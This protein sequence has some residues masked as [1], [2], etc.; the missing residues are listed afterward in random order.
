MMRQGV[1]QKEKVVLMGHSLGAFISVH[2][3]LTFPERVH[4][5]ILASPVGVPESPNNFNAETIAENM[6]SGSKKLFV[7]QIGKSWENH[8]SPFSIM[9][10]GGSITANKLLERYVNNRITLDSKEEKDQMRDLLHQAV[11]RP[12]SSEVAITMVLKFGAYAREPLIHLI[13][14]LKMKVSFLYGDMDWM[15]RD[16][17][18]KLYNEGSLKRGS[19]VVTVPNAGHNLLVDNP[20]FVAVWIYGQVFGNQN[21]AIYQRKLNVY[22]SN[23]EESFQKLS[24]L[25]Q[26]ADN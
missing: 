10:A 7:K 24:E 12:C 1:Q 8:T 17:A 13:P 23:R 15:D 19:A 5:L 26:T 9:R 20:S 3:A 4:Q 25:N 11:M 14:N 18:D 21:K 2:Y 22:L 16:A 6:E